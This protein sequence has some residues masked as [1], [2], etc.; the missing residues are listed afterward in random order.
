MKILIVKMSSLGDV[1]HTLPVLPPLRKKFPNANI[2]W[3]IEEEI[4]ELIID[5]PLIE[6]VL[7]LPKKR[8][9]R[10]LANCWK[11]PQI[12]QE[13]FEFIEELRSIEYDLV[14]DFQGLFKSGIFTGICRGKQKVG[15]FP[16]KE[17]SHIFLN[18][19][20]PFPRS[21]LHALERYIYLIESLGC[22]RPEI[23]FL[24][25]IRQSHRNKVLEFF[26]EKKIGPDDTIVLLHP[27][28]RWKTKLWEEEKWAALGDFLLQK[29][30]I[31][32]IFTGSYSDAP[33]VKRII[34]RMKFTGIDAAGKW[35]LKELAFLQA[36]ADVI[37]I[38]DSGP[39]HLAAA[40][41]TP[42]VALFGP[43]D[44]ALTGPFGSI[45][46]VIVSRVD[47]RPCFLRECSSR[48]CMNQIT[49]KEVWESI[50]P[51]LS[52]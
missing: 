17:K 6:R 15:F 29:R 41:G 47:C 27:G 49:V 48:R 25:P 20:V 16:A 51:Y 4:A 1:I 34:N 21:S 5:H 22:S 42:V 44:P 2:A 12:F 52:Y 46:K 26:R 38:P 32:V 43:T 3:L 45:H 37:V 13:L 8:W 30:G 19:R 11:W 50:K 10:G 18:K 7:I 40:M 24:I 31:R 23:E 36:L 9:L 39:M 14:I 33:L 28:T 35:G